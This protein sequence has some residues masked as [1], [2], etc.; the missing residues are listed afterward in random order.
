MSDFIEEMAPIGKNC[1]PL[2]IRNETVDCPLNGRDSVFRITNAVFQI[3]NFYGEDKGQSE[4]GFSLEKW[5]FIRGFALTAIKE[6]VDSMSTINICGCCLEDNK[7]GKCGD[8]EMRG[9]ARSSCGKHVMRAIGKTLNTNSIINSLK[10]KE[11]ETTDKNLCRPVDTLFEGR[12]IVLSKESS[13]HVKKNC[14]HKG[15]NQ[16]TD[17][18]AVLKLCGLDEKK[19]GFCGC[20]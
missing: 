1:V 9:Y 10:S 12:S 6:H 4:F 2:P 8:Y 15:H 18:H 20:K 13:V 5:N 17:Q 7:D 19:P 14:F 11:M 16:V 3:C